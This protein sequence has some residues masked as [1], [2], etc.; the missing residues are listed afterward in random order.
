MIVPCGANSGKSGGALVFILVNKMQTS[1]SGD[2]GKIAYQNFD[3]KTI[4]ITSKILQSQ[5]LQVFEYNS[6]HVR[7]NQEL[8]EENLVLKTLD[9]VMA[10]QSTYD[11]IKGTE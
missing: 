1:D 8:F 4:C 11:F 3:A 5:I 6:L 9:M 7:V 10:T 2:D